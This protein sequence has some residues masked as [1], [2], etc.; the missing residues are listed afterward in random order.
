MDTSVSTKES[1]LLVAETPGIGLYA[2]RGLH[3]ALKA[4]YAAVPGA[5]L[6]VEI[7]GKVVDVLLP[8]ELVEIQ[9]RNLGAIVDKLL[10]LAC[11]MPVRVVHPIVVEKIIERLDPSD[12]SLASTRRSKT[13]R[14]LYSLFDELVRASLIVASPNIRFD[15]LLVSVREVRVRDGSGSWRRRGDRVCSRDLDSVLATT[16]LESRADWMALLPPGLPEPFDSSSLGVA[17]G[18]APA[19]ARKILYTF[20]HAGLLKEAGIVGRR[21]QYLIASE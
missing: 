9:T 14:D 20:A 17:L 21:K 2:E 1:F 6:E 16:R 7:A 10:H 11:L 15:V 8:D 12:G 3:S 18:M 13:R 5:R 4:A 19:R